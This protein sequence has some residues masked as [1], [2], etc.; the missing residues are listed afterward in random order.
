MTFQSDDPA[1]LDTTE[2]EF[3]Q[4]WDEAEP[5]RVIGPGERSP[6]TET[7]K[8]DH[9]CDERCVC[10]IHETELM[11]APAWNEHACTDIYCEF[12]HGLEDNIFDWMLDV[13][14]R[15]RR[16]IRLVQ[17]LWAKVDI[18]AMKLDK[19]TDDAAS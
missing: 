2:D 10:P 3:D 13:L 9:R 7:M 19:E 6:F 11:Y 1:E 4:M 12:A 17:H 14:A 16:A 15:Q 8:T 5:T 18:T